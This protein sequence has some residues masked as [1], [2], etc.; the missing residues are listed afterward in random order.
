[1]D[2]AVAIVDFAFEPSRLDVAAG[3]TATWTNTGQAPHTATASEGDSDTGRLDEG[4]VARVAFD[5]PGTY[6]YACQFHPEMTGTV[7]VT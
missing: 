1:V 5:A 7:V 4:A 3:T 6:P 2:A